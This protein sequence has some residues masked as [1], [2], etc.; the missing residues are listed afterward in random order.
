MNV[1]LSKGYYITA[2]LR[3]ID[4]ETT[5][6]TKAELLNL[7][8]QTRKEPGCSLFQLHECPDDPLRLL[9]WE[10]FDDEAAYHQ[11][12]AESHTLVYK[13]LNLTKVIQFFASNVL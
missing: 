7:C 5:K 12:F 4:P 10:R 1:Q 9:L 11:H 3:I 13:N 2:E 8:E 6:R